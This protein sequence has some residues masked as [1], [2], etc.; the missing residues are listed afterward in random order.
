[1]SDDI[2]A[3]TVRI[4]SKT[5]GKIPLS[6]LPVGKFANLNGSIVYRYESVIIK[7]SGWIPGCWLIEKHNHLTPYD[8]LI[9]IEGESD[10]QYYVTQIEKPE[11]K[12]LDNAIAHLKDDCKKGLISGLLYLEHLTRLKELLRAYAKK[13]ETNI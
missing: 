11:K 1:M 3:E 6:E 13:K 7:G 12:H 2:V 4:R 8:E 9:C 10:W 5:A